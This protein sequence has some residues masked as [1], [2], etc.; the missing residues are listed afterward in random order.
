MPP[1]SNVKVGQCNTDSSGLEKGL[2]DQ[3]K[4]EVVYSVT[5]L[6]IF[7]QTIR[8]VAVSEK[9]PTNGHDVSYNARSWLSVS[10]VT[11]FRSLV[12]PQQWSLIVWNGFL[13]VGQEK[14]GEGDST[15][16][17]DPF[18]RPALALAST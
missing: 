9:S 17:R 13:H 10:L 5:S 16:S 15:T 8:G 2:E 4:Q 1:A 14:V 7:S 3:S 6:E 18:S 12:E 11:L